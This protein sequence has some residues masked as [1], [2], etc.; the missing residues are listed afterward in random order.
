MWEGGD[1]IRFR[2][3]RKGSQVSSLVVGSGRREAELRAL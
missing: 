2:Q 1:S 3:E